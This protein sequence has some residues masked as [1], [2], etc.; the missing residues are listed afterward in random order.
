MTHPIPAEELHSF[1]RCLGYHF[2]K[3]N[4][5][6]TA[7]THSSYAYEYK[8]GKIS[9]NERLEF[10]GDGVLGFVIADELFRRKWRRNEGYLSKT[11]ALIVCEEMLSEIAGRLGIPGI[12]L[13][14]KGEDASG[15]RNKPSNLSNA[16][17]AVFGAVYLDGG[18]S[19]VQKTILSV[20]NESIERA[21][22]GSLI[23]D[24]KSRL[25][26]WSQSGFS[27]NPLSFVIL[28]ENGPVHHRTYTAAVLLDEKI[29]GKGYGQSKKSAEQEAAR[30]A[31]D[32]IDTQKSP[33]D[34]FR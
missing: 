21:I 5:L 13:L 23:F 29:I 20:M 16:L 24:Y 25:L 27:E 10:L 31:M 32:R 22:A 11:R 14:G 1:Q 4:Y 18:F 33:D 34:F 7:L 2:L 28:D 6:I 12:L 15:G 17:E 8:E 3:T 26:E 9:D 30:D 19:A